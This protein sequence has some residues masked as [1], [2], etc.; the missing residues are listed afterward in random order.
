[1]LFYTL[2]VNLYPKKYHQFQQFKKIKNL[3]Y[4]FILECSHSQVNKLVQEVLA[5][6]L[7]GFYC[8]TSFGITSPTYS[9]VTLLF[10]SNMLPM[11]N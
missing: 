11:N 3:L 1:M 9:G 2:A 8:L 7:Q 10:Y 5:I 6:L 4:I